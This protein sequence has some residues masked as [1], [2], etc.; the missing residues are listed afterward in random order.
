[1][2][3]ADRAVQAQLLEL[4]QLEAGAVEKITIVVDQVAN[5]VPPV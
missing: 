5:Q 1:M 4:P 3:E 2:A